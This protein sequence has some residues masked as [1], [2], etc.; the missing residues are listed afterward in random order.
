VVFG[1]S[2]GGP[3]SVLYAA[4][5]AQRVIGLI[6]FGTGPRFAWAPD[7]PWG[8]TEEQHLLELEEIDREWGTEE[9]AARQIRDWGAP[10]Q[11]ED[12]HLVSCWPDTSGERQA[13][14][15][16]SPWSG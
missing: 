16:P 15:R 12:P 1:V 11:P 5:H 14:E 9:Y 10:S 4:T 7:Y 2:E 13:L 8:T 3:L 6:L